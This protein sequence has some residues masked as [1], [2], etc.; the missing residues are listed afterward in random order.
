VVVLCF[1]VFLL[2]LESTLVWSSCGGGRTYTRGTMEHSGLD[3]DMTRHVTCLGALEFGIGGHSGVTRSLC[4]SRAGSD[5]TYIP[6]GRGFTVWAGYLARVNGSG[7]FAFT[8][9]IERGG[10]GRPRAHF[11]HKRA[12]HDREAAYQDPAD[13]YGGSGQWP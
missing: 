6:W 8:G 11:I 10:H 12:F 9:T 13:I 2:C 5:C 7:S 4:T 1:F 3:V